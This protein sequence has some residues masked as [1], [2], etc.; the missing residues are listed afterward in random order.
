MPSILLIEDD[1]GLRKILKAGLERAEF[2]VATASGGIK[3]LEIIKSNAID[4]VV[5]DIVMSEGEGVETLRWI[6]ETNPNLPVIVMSGFSQYLG[7]MKNLG[8]TETL[9]KPFK[10]F[11]LVR[12]IYAAMGQKDGNIKIH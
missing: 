6:K 5:T 4:V 8:A 12:A 10:I 11:E 9:K 2:G 7:S 3:G 1:D